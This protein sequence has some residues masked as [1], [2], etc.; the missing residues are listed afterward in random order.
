MK[1]VAHVTENDFK[2]SE[3]VR[4]VKNVVE[5]SHKCKTYL[6]ENEKTPYIDG[7]IGILQGGIYRLTVDVQ[8][9]TLPKDAYNLKSRHFIPRFDHVG[10]FTPMNS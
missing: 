1:N 2:E 10:T 5:A 4:F 7:H 8:I 3:S 9:R 6:L